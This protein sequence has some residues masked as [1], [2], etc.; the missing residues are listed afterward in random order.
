MRKFFGSAF[1]LVAVLLFAATGFALQ[2]S[3]VRFAGDERDE[4][5]ASEATCSIHC[6]NICLRWVWVWHGF[7]DDETIGTVFNNCCQ[8]GVLTGSYQYFPTGAPPAYGYTGWAMV[9]EVKGEKPHL[10]GLVWPPIA[11]IPYVSYGGGW[12][13]IAWGVPVGQR[14]AVSYSIGD[15]NHWGTPVNVYSDGPSACGVCFPTDR[16]TK[17]YNFGIAEVDSLSRPIY[18]ENPGTPLFDGQCY[19][20]W[21]AA[22][23]IKCSVAIE[24]ESWSSIK[25]LYR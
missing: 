23:T 16:T 13:F 7:F 10:E 17:S 8:G 20:E 3:P 6:Y 2:K 14:F 4:W 1:V 22:V 5:A 19:V 18:T 15:N 25:N 9:N 12:E 21:L 24:D 11:Q